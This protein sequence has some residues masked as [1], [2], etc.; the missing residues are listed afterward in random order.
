MVMKMELHSFTFLVSGV[1]PTSDDFEQRF[2]EAGCDDATLA[3]MNG[4]LAVCF[5]R[6]EKDFS[7]AVIS[8]YSDILK[9]DVCIERFE[10]DF[11]V[12]KTEIAKRACITRAAVTNYAN[13]ERGDDFPKP[14]ARITTK[15]PLWDWV[16]VSTWLH[17]HGKLSVAD[18]INARIC[19][20]VNYFVQHP[21]DEPKKGD[22]LFLKEMKKISDSVIVA[23]C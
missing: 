17:K 19:R 13:G 5:D 1:D 20:S 3:L 6:E 11:L 12:S 4:L 23:T 21:D 14:F 8:A 2:V 22:E 7:H 15:S 18:V 10:P 16:E 9:A